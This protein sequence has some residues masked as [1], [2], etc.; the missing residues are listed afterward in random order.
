MHGVTLSIFI[1]YFCQI[2]I[3]GVIR[4]A[5]YLPPPKFY[6]DLQNL[7]LYFKLIQNVSLFIPSY[8]VEFLLPL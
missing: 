6:N 7:H 3:H 4:V 2:S 8:I 5:V 1:N